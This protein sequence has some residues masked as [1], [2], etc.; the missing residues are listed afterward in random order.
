MSGRGSI[1][2]PTSRPTAHCSSSSLRGAY[3]ESLLALPILLKSSPNLAEIPGVILASDELQGFAATCCRSIAHRSRLTAQSHVQNSNLASSCSAN[4]F[5][6]AH[7][8]CNDSS[9]AYP[10]LARAKNSQLWI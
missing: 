2:E 1:K 10:S 7:D 4:R 3:G 5:K 8:A 9:S 6:F